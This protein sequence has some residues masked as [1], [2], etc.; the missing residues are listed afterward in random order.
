[1]NFRIDTDDI[2]QTL[3]KTN[4]MRAC[5]GPPVIGGVVVD[6]VLCAPDMP[7]RIHAVSS[8][9]VNR[10]VTRNYRL[11]QPYTLLM[12]AHLTRVANTFCNRSNNNVISSEL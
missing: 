1:M 6:F 12:R 2:L 3:S 7:H 11:N 5:C 8:D 4:L 9:A 10:G